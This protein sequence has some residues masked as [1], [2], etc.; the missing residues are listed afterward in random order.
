VSG[1]LRCIRLKGE[2]VGLSQL[3]DDVVK[4][5]GAL[6]NHEGGKEKNSNSSLEREWLAQH[7]GGDRAHGAFWS[8]QLH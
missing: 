1:S 6:N 8:R 4:R 3:H 5:G 2:I 7:G